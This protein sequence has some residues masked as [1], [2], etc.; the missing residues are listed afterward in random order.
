[1]SPAPTNKTATC[2]IKRSVLTNGD[3]QIQNADCSLKVIAKDKVITP[4]QG[5]TTSEGQQA[6]V[7][8]V[9]PPVKMEPVRSA[10]GKPAPAA[11]AQ[12]TEIKPQPLPEGEADPTLRARYRDSMLGYYDY[13]IA[14]Y[15]HR[16]RT[17]EWQ[18]ISSIL[19]FILVCT[20]V[21]AG[22]YFAALQFP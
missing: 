1:M 11:T 16:Q 2:P 18:F 14:G 20:L 15:R 6:Q 19:I 10:A 7:D 17:F 22:V 12:A 9:A 21:S 5:S 13:H 4:P 3:L 8:P